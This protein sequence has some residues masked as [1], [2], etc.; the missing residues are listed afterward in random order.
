MGV[1]HF[2]FD[3]SARRECGHRVDDHDVDRSGAGQHVADL[4]SLLTSVWLGDQELI[5]VD[6]DRCCVHRVHCVLGI[7]V[8]AYATI[9]LRFSND[10]HGK[11]GLT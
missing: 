3:L 2:P 5:D 9:A 1:A 11:R 7:D 6:A 4:E 8:G 10:V